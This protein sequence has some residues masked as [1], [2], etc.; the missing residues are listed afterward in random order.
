MQ[1]TGTFCIYNSYLHLCCFLTYYYSFATKVSLLDRLLDLAF[2]LTTILSQRRYHC[3]VCCLTSEAC[4]TCRPFTFFLTSTL[5]LISHKTVSYTVHSYS[6]AH[7]T[8]SEKKS[9]V[10]VTPHQHHPSHCHSP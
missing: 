5:H 4:V 1:M 9:H 8:G 7:K 10:W 3:P 2:E 6:L